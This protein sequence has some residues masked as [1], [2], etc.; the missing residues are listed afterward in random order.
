M[1][2]ELDGPLSPQGGRSSS[3]TPEAITPTAWSQAIPT[4]ANV[5]SSDG[6][7]DEWV[8]PLRPATT[9][10]EEVHDDAPLHED[11]VYNLPPVWKRLRPSKQDAL[12]NAAAGIKEATGRED[13]KH[14]SSALDPYGHVARLLTAG[15]GHSQ[16]DQLEV[17]SLPSSPDL[18]EETDGFM[19]V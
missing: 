18:E 9:R 14:V 10:E 11:L 16:L 5:T 3:S 6:G 1:S 8:L 17:V 4:R 2:R 12:R 13:L 15:H 19:L 7:E